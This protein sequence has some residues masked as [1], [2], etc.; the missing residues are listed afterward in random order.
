MFHHIPRTGGVTLEAAFRE[1]YGRGNVSSADGATPDL[2][3]L[4][5]DRP[6]YMYDF[7]DRLHIT[8]LRDPIERLLSWLR[9]HRE[10]LLGENLLHPEADTH[11]GE[12]Y[13]QRVDDEKV[14]HGVRDRFVRQLGGDW[15]HDPI[16]IETAFAIA[17]G[18]LNRMF[19][20]GQTETLDTDMARLFD[21]L[22]QPNPMISPQ[23]ASQGPHIDLD[24]GVLE[25]LTR[26]DRR[27]IEAWN[28]P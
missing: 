8:I 22:D 25:E 17:L 14:A 10:G 9:F 12:E 2:Q 4:V 7:P 18:R 16:P 24:M 13:L 20:V 6:Y 27:L 15:R 5:T 1:I 3:V 19:W 21:M 23:N 26:W 11:P 28:R